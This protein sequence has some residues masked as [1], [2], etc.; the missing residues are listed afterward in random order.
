MF[1][2]LRHYQ[3]QPGHRDEWVEYME[4]V[5]IPFMT[6]KGMVITASFIDEANSGSYVWMRRFEDEAHR[7]RAYT[8]AYESDEWKRNIL[9]TVNQWLIREETTVT[10]LIPTPKSPVR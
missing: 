5:V 10:R 7:D 1:Y 2:E 4:D 8:A 3:I 9:P 6:S